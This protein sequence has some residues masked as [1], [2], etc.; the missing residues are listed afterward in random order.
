MREFKTLSGRLIQA[1]RYRTQAVRLRDCDPARERWELW[2]TTADGQEEK[3]VVASRLMPARSEHG[4]TLIPLDDEPFGMFN[5]DAGYR[6]NF[7][8]GDSA[9][10]LRP[11]DVAPPSPRDGEPILQPAPT[12]A[13]P[14][15][16]SCSGRAVPSIHV[17]RQPR[18]SP[19]VDGPAK[20]VRGCPCLV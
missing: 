7:A 20:A 4:V 5:L 6:V 18:P 3:H 9:L 16:A 14:G 12:L 19:A 11:V 1:R 17:R 13:V 8:R 10:L 2:L 15:T